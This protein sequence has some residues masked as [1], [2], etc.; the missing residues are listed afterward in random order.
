ML[1]LSARRHL[2]LACRLSD[3]VAPGG[4][5]GAPAGPSTRLNQRRPPA[6]QGERPAGL[7]YP[8][9]ARFGADVARG[10]GSLTIRGKEM[11]LVVRVDSFTTTASP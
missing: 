1:E 9:L 10:A 6:H 3:L 8:S 2:A 5:G 7:R 11:L 4:N